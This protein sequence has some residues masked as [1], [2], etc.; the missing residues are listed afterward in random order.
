MT[1]QNSVVRTIPR[2]PAAD[3]VEPRSTELGFNEYAA[4]VEDGRVVSGSQ[5]IL[6]GSQLQALNLS[7]EEVV[8]FIDNGGVVVL[9]PSWRAE[10]PRLMLLVASIVVAIYLTVLNSG[11]FVGILPMYIFPP[12]AVAATI[13]HKRFNNKYTL[14]STHITSVK[15]LLSVRYLRMR[16]GFEQL[17]AIEVEKTIID[18]ILNTGSVRLSTV[19]FDQPEVILRR[20]HNPQYYAGIIK[21][22]HAVYQPAPVPS[23]TEE[24]LKSTLID[25]G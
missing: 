2:P 5:E 3:S 14:S 23:R 7:I 18:R 19:M 9:R 13:M 17:K 16:L 24:A 11:S 25:E 1:T 4:T 22:K 10:I 8:E 15:G 21:V 6:R 20:I 12:L